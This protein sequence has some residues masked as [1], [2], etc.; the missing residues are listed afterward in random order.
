MTEPEWFT[1]VDPEEMLGFLA[2]KASERK[3]RLVAAACCRRIWDLLTDDRSRDGVEAAERFADG[4][5]TPEELDAARDNADSAEFSLRQTILMTQAKMDFR[6]PWGHLEVLAKHMASLAAARS[7]GALPTPPRRPL[8]ESAEFAAQAKS[9]APEAAA[10]A[11]SAAARKAERA[12]QGDLM[13]E[14]VGNPFRPVDLPS[15]WLSPTV[16]GLAAA[17]YEARDL[18]AGRLDNVR[19][20]V[21]ADALEEAGCDHIGMLNHCRQAG[22]HVRG[23]WVVDLLLRKS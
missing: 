8:L 23:C 2:G 20:A 7:A 13:R 5:L 9:L 12:A 15:A 11:G 21:L 17:A 1:C 22:A 10:G 16:T 18:P 3:L 6:S 4:L 19:L 14:I